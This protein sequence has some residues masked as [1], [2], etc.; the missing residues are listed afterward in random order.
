MAPLRLSSPCRT[1]YLD[2][3]RI[4]HSILDTLRECAS[5]ESNMA[6]PRACC[7]HFPM[8]LFPELESRC[9]IV[10][11]QTD[12]GNSGYVCR[13]KAGSGNLVAELE[14][15]SGYRHPSECRRPPCIEGCLSH[16]DRRV[17]PRSE[18]CEEGPRYPFRNGLRRTM[19]RRIGEANELADFSRVTL[20]SLVDEEIYGHRVKL[21]QETDS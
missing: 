1:D 14:N 19:G 17:P 13:E 15:L 2:E 10:D 9:H 4:V 5:E 18:S 12:R 11:L 3:F 16:V 8:R 7:K 6:P 21:R 20:A